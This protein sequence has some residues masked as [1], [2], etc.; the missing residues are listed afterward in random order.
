M[1]T[2]RECERVPIGRCAAYVYSSTRVALAVVY[3]YFACT[4]AHV[5]AVR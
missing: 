4:G 2:G 5:S 1:P 3:E